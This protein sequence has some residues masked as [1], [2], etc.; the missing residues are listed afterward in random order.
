MNAKK[1]I[2]KLFA[3]L[4]VAAMVAPVLAATVS[5]KPEFGEARFAPADKLHAECLNSVHVGL[6]VA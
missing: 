1:I 4:M 2:E 5:I 3:V 6:D